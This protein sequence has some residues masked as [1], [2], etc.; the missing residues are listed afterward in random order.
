[1]IKAVFASGKKGESVKDALCR[2][3]ETPEIWL[4]LKS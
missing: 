4:T 2:G 1:M 3:L